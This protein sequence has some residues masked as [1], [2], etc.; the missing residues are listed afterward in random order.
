MSGVEIPVIA[1]LHERRRRQDTGS[2]KY[3]LTVHG[4]PYLFGREPYVGAEAA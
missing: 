1:E 3:H 4:V 2:A